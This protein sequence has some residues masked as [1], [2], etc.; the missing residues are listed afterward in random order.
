MDRREF[1]K[2]LGLGGAA[3][4]TAAVVGCKGGSQGETG[5][6]LTDIPKGQMTL[7]ENHNSGDKVSILGYG[8]MRWPTKKGKDG[9]ESRNGLE[10]QR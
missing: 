7:K 6:S 1:I 8:C 9:K 2:K 5:S 4:G 10:I 3:V